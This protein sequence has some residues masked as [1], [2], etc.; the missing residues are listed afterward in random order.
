VYHPAKGYFDDISVMTC[1]PDK[2]V[3]LQH[4]K[5][6]FFCLATTEK[7]VEG[8]KKDKFTQAQITIWNKKKDKDAYY[9]E[10]KDQC[11]VLIVYS[12]TYIA[13]SSS[14]YQQDHPEEVVTTHSRRVYRIP[15][16]RIG[17]G[18]T[19]PC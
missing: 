14:I 19:S 6:V 4:L 17:R 9:S 13:V 7:L 3:H 1:I 10:C 8:Q 5:N 16:F 11:S 12:F 18:Y 15:P 2:K